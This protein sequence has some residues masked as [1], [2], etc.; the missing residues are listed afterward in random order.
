MAAGL[1]PWLLGLGLALGPAGVW[2]EWKLVEAGGGQRAPGDSVLLSC[3]GHGFDL[4]VYYMYWYR[5]APGGRMEWVSFIYHDSS[6]IRYGRAVDGRATVSRDNSRSETSL[7]LSALSPQ[8][9]ARYFCATRVWAA[10]VLTDKLV[11]GSGTTLT[12]EPSNR[13]HS[14]PQVVVLKSKQLEGDGNSG[15]A[16]CLARKFHTKNVTLE[17]SSSEVIYQPT[18]PILSPE[19]LYDTVKVVNVTKGT[20]VSCTAKYDGR[21]VTANETPPEK[22]AGESAP[23]DVCHT[24]DTS[25]QDA[26]GE[27]TNMLSVAVL[28]LRVLLAKSIAFNALM[29]IK[30]LLF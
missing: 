13:N 28:G 25:A 11:F 2:A 16:A 30:L 21:D 22:E 8:D 6:V 15:K 5:Q 23:E 9:S 24:T 17:V 14:E 7:S 4:G 20:E 18:T 12:V 27:K 26:E 19:G 10:G 3:R 29:S 1:G